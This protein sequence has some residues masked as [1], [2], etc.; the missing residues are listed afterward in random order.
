[1]TSRHAALK[2]ARAPAARRRTSG[3][4]RPSLR[5]VHGARLADDRH[6]DLAGIL[7]LLLDLARNVPR[8]RDRAVVVDVVGRD[9]HAD[10]AA[11]LHRVDLVDAGVARRDV[12]EIAQAL[13]VLLERLAASAGAR[14]TQRVGSLHDDRL[15]GLR[16][17]LVVVGLHRVGDG[18]RLA[19]A[20]HEVP[21]D[22]G[23][24]ALDLV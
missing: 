4:R 24:W 8:E 10:L 2:G 5:V 20:A 12:L 18:L 16:L 22:E 1:M 17:D 15:D 11:G 7:E 19:V 3:A 23:V 21:A 14:A 13:D 9:D 6:L